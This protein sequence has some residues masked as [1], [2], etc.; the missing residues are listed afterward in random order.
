MDQLE[1]DLR[2]LIAKH[3]LQE[4]YEK[5]QRILHTDYVFLSTLFNKETELPIELPLS[6][7]D[8][9]SKSEL[10]PVELPI[11]KE[12]KPVKLAPK[13]PSNTD[14]ISSL[15]PSK[16]TPGMKLLVMKDD[17]EDERE[18]EKEEEQEEQKKPQFTSSKEAKQWQKEQE[19]LRR[20]QNER[21]GIQ[22][23][24]LLTPENMK[25]W[26]LEEKKPYSTIARDIIG[27][28]EYRIADYAKQNNIISDTAKRRAAIIAKRIKAKKN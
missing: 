24:S 18:D 27:L 6:H 2:T 23:E 14:Q 22:P 5:F 8:L 26:V 17:Q 15:V 3:G 21:N 28:P 19:E 4:T 1:Q 16:F 9:T 25:K 7:G 20:E 11:Q 10:K 12:K 13:Q